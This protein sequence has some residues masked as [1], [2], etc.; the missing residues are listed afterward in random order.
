M[1]AEDELKLYIQLNRR[2]FDVCMDIPNEHTCTGTNQ[3]LSW[4]NGKIST[5]RIKNRYGLTKHFQ[6]EASRILLNR[7]SLFCTTFQSR[8][9]KKWSHFSPLS[10]FCGMTWFLHSP[11]SSAGEWAP[12]FPQGQRKTNGSFPQ[13]L[14]RSVK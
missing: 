10:H 4:R 11:G 8:W 1:K 9:W 12:L 13:I 5:M 3:S 2:T 14:L 7:F 6:C